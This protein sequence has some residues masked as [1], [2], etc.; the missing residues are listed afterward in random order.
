LD[1]NLGIGPTTQFLKAQKIVK[2]HNHANKKILRLLTSNP[3]FSFWLLLHFKLGDFSDLPQSEW[4][5]RVEQ[6]LNEFIP[7][8]K[9]AE[10]QKE[11]FNSSYPFLKT[12]IKNSQKLQLIRSIKPTP[13]SDIHELMAYLLKLHRRYGS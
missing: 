10:S 6:E 1:I 2:Q 3:G 11:Y 7:N 13:S 8:F 9:S 5:Q 12:A 4:L